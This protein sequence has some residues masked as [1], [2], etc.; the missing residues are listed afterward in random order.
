MKL[1]TI[2]YF[3][4][5]LLILS[6]TLIRLIPHAPNFSPVIAISLYAGIKFNNRYLALLVPI[7]SMFISD[8]FI[9]LHSSMLAVYFCI[10]LNVLLGIF[11]N[12]KFTLLNYLYLSLIGSCLFFIITNFSVWLLSNMYPL[13]IEGLISCYVL[14]LPFF[15]NTLISALIFGSLLFYTNDRFEKYFNRNNKILKKI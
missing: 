12:K 15:H 2:K 11:F 7:L 9:G 1:H 6:L 10:T 4:P 3:Y 5:I 8:C 13:T 14:A